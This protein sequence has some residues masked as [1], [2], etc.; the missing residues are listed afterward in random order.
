MEDL[1]ERIRAFLAK[2]YGYGDGSGDGSGYGDGDGDGSG[3][4][5]G[6]G[7]GYGDGDGDG[8]GYGSGVGSGV[9]GGVV[10]G[11]GG[12]RSFNRQPVWMIDNT[13]TIIESIHGSYA[14]GFVLHSDFSTSPCFIAKAD[15]RY[16][17]HGGSLRQAFNDA[18]AKA[19]A[20]MSED[21]RIAKFKAEYP[22]PDA[23]IPTNDLFRWHNILTGS[24]E[25]GRREFCRSHGIDIDRDSFSTAE[26]VALTRNDYG[27][28]IIKRLLN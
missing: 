21:E 11:V 9:G 4:G 23:K 15:G 5:S 6:Y 3:D 12:I 24:C 17:A 28:D 20:N 22:D 19:L 26:F 7:G 14:K 13:P 27:G 1:I 25:F 18:R 10:G 16:F 2:D 8:S